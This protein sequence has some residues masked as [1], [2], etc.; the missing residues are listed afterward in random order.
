MNFCQKVF[1][2]WGNGD[3]NNFAGAYTLNWA[4]ATLAVTKLTAGIADGMVS[5]DG[6]EIVYQKGTGPAGQIV[7]KPFSGGTETA[8]GTG[9]YPTWGGDS[10]TIGY[11]NSD[12]TGY[13]VYSTQTG[14][15]KTYALPQGTAI[16]HPALSWGGKKIAFRAFGGANTGI[17]IGT[18]VD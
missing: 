15:S 12:G 4:G 11:L 18:L 14:A 16:Q 2:I 17:K 6:N 10:K 13:V 1:A 5:R 8:V 7:W 9:M 3:I